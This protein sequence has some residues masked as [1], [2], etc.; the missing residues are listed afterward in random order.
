MPG[1]GIVKLLEDISSSLIFYYDFHKYGLFTIN[2][3]ENK[4]KTEFLN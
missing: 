4:V 1:Y 3:K 2:L